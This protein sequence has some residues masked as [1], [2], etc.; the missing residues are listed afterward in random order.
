MKPA[1]LVLAGIVAATSFAAPAGAATASPAEVAAPTRSAAVGDA[2]VGIGVP[3]IKAR[4]RA[5]NATRMSAQDRRCKAAVTAAMPS[6]WGPS[7]HT[8]VCKPGRTQGYDLWFDGIAVLTVN[9]RLSPAQW[10]QAATWGASKVGRP[11]RLPLSAAP[12]L[13]KQAVRTYTGLARSAG[14][15]RVRCVSRIT[16]QVPDTTVRDMAVQGFIRYDTKDIAILATRD[17][18]GMG[19]VTA[20]ELG[21]A[22]AASPRAAGLRTEVTRSTRRRTFTSAPYVGMPA[23]V[24]AESFARYWTRQSPASVQPGRLSAAKVDALLRKYRLPRR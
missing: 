3:D 9:S 11:E 15:Y 5:A 10:K 24:W 22:V 20:H 7:G 2:S 18:A 13:C 1:S 4:V 14:N 12:G 17:V 19:F 23:E 21:H 8:V 16:W 6:W